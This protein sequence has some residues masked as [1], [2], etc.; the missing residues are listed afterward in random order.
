MAGTDGA[1]G[2]RDGRRQGVFNKR[3]DK[4]HSEGCSVETMGSARAWHGVVCWFRRVDVP[5]P[6]RGDSDKR[7][8]GDVADACGALRGSRSRE[9]A[10]GYSDHR[11]Q[12]W[13]DMQCSGQHDGALQPGEVGGLHGRG[14]GVSRS[15]W[16]QPQWMASTAAVVPRGPQCGSE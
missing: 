9:K 14:D 7:W 15:G 12:C 1:G 11:G 6:Q 3:L 13:D 8:H 5:D 2:G 10:D 16:Q 4:L